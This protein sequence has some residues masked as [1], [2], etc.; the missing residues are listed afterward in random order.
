MGAVKSLHFS[1]R[2]SYTIPEFR[3]VVRDSR[4]IRE[5][6]T[7]LNLSP[8]GGNYKVFHSTVS[9]L[10]ISVSHFTGQA[11]N[12]GGESPRQRI[13]LT[14]ILVKNSQYQSSKLRLRLLS[15][16][17]FDHKC[18]NCETST[19]MGCAIP[20]ELEH[21]DGDSTNNELSNLTLLCPN[22]HALTSTYRGK[23]I[24]KT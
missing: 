24:R 11:W 14:N 12:S 21:K 4:S 23:N 17:I 2:R 19:W 7:K 20:L 16:N 6:L 1:P 18:Y 15:E 22:C 9:Q 3:Q 8:C 10:G 13:P 5:C